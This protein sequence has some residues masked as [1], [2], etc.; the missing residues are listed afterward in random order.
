MGLSQ[1]SIESVEVRLAQ[2]EEEI[3]AAQHLRYKVF[4]EEYSA[5]PT[6]DM[7]AQR[8]DFDSFDDV[9][10]HLVAIDHSKSDIQEKIVGTYRLLRQ[11]IAQKHGEFYTS[12]EYNI[13]SLVNCGE[14][15]LELGRSCVLADYRTRPILQKLWEA[16]VDYTFRHDLGL[17]FGCASLHG[18]DIN[19]LALQL[20]YLHHFH[21]APDKFKA[22]A[23]KN[24]YIDMNII[25]KSDIE[26]KQAFKELPPL[27]KGYLRAGAYIGEGA[28]IDHQFNTTDVCIILPVHQI[29]DRYKN[30]YTRKINKAADDK[31]ELERKTEEDAEQAETVL[32]RG[33]I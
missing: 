21:T 13:S 17:L 3:R 7:A 23:V 29:A 32:A 1:I 24:R 22:V 8:R 11:D 18:T 9:T 30:H 10:D 6:E 2:S 28:V 14:P 26:I 4:Y 5:T 12:S 31:K 15:L 16:I 27:V 20:S 19:A 25:P 33:S